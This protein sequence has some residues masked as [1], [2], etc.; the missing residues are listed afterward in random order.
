MHEWSERSPTTIGL[1]V[2]DYLGVRESVAELYSEVKLF[3]VEDLF[4]L[5]APVVS[6]GLVLGMII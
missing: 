2:T 1:N 3:R 5:W 6:S 4:R